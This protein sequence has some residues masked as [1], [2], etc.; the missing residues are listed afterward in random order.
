MLNIK[1]VTIKIAGN[2]ERMTRVQVK[3]ERGN[4]GLKV[5]KMTI[6]ITSR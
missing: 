1:L 3:S 6:M 5:R 4:S 2:R